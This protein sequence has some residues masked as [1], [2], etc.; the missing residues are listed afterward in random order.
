M[1]ASSGT[2]RGASKDVTGYTGVTW[3]RGAFDYWY[4]ESQE[5]FEHP[6]DPFVHIDALSSSRLVTARHDGVVL[7]ESREAIFLWET[8][9]PTRYYLPRKD[10]NVDLLTRSRSESICPYKGFATDYW[11]VSGEPSLTDIAWSYPEPLFAYRNIAG[12]VAFLNEQ[13]EILID[14][15]MQ[16]RPVPKRWPARS[17]LE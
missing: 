2:G 4:E 10:I 12:T 9:L 8:G 5:V 7:G 14:N 11:S 1:P 16:T 6:H 15:V 3:E 13:L 17:R